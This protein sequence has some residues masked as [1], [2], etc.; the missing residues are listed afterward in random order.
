M[1]VTASFI[2]A[3]LAAAGGNALATAAA[4]PQ[5]QPKRYIIELKSQSHIAHIQAMVE[6]TT[7]MRVFQT[8]DH[9]VFPAVSVECH[10]GHDVET[11]TQS[12]RFDGEDDPGVDGI[13]E[14]VPLQ[15][16]RPIEGQSF[17][18]D[19]AALNYSFHGMTGVEK[20]HKDGI[21]G[22]GATVAVIDTGIDYTHP[23]LG[24][25]IGDGYKVIGGLNLVGASNRS[26]SGPGF[27]DDSVQD[28]KGHGTHVA[29]IVA[30]KGEQFIGVAPDAKLLAY[31]V[32]YPDGNIWFEHIR[33]AIN[34]AWDDGA[35]IITLSLGAS[36]PDRSQVL[37]GTLASKLVSEGVFVSV[38]AGNDGKR[39]PFTLSVE[40]VDADILVV[41]ASDPDRYPAYKF[42]A[43]HHL[44]SRSDKTELAYTVWSLDGKKSSPPMPWPSTLVDW[45]IVPITRNISISNDACSS[46]AQST[47]NMTGTIVL[48]RSGGCS[49]KE[50]LGN[51]EPF[52]PQY[53]LFY[54]DDSPFQ[55]PP[56]SFKYEAAVI[57]KAAGEAIIKT[58]LE[59]GNVTASFDVDLSHYVGVYNSGGGR[60]WEMSSW[61]PTRN[62]ELKPDVSAPG[63]AECCSSSYRVQNSIL[64]AGLRGSYQIM[65]GT[66]MA[67]P[68]IAGV[69]KNGGRAAHANDPAWAQRLMKRITSTAHSVPWLDS[70]SAIVSKFFASPAQVGTGFVDAARVMEA[71]TELSFHGRGFELKDPAR[72]VSKHSVNITNAG[73]EP[74]TYTFSLQGAGGF[75]SSKHLPGDWTES[76]PVVP[77]HLDPLVS[78]P[79]AVI[80]GAGE[81]K[82]VEFAFKPPTNMNSSSYPFYSGK[83]LIKANNSEEFGIPYLGAGHNIKLPDTH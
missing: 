50:K 47:A 78:F 16:I 60:P 18:N 52:S 59:G 81:T 71:T 56:V 57:D 80:V 17:S 9:A 14:S 27:P 82:A 65:S 36:P 30:G 55:T 53:V 68:Y 33:N 8:F 42:T 41:A 43:S 40:A 31:K 77:M 22:E 10:G 26:P 28:T 12:F 61:G 23:A 66:S 73:L 79:K 51:L 11:M 5:S 44:G 62:L 69:G 15:I 25:G 34:K 1:R 6:R 32:S 64:S 2:V 39:G 70:N 38:A 37:W 49:L 35:D 74:V 24:G 58:I 7:G 54:Q 20:L 63:H 76:D 13:Y 67:T 83:V 3:L 4:G 19:A 75:D 45:P 72:F 21:T 48:V 29:G 46:L